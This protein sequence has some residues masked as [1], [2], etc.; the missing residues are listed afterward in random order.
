MGV[1]KVTV[2]V[3]FAEDAQA[4]PAEVLF[5]RSA[6]H[7]V[8]AVNFLRRDTNEEMSVRRLMRKLWK[9]KRPLP[10]K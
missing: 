1:V 3:D 2:W 10:S 4:Q 5:T 9:I 7:L 6:G 8:T